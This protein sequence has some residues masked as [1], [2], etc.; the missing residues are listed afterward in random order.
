[1]RATLF[2]LEPTSIAEQ[3]QTGRWWRR[4]AVGVHLVASRADP[5]VFDRWLN[6]PEFFHWDDVIWR[7]RVGWLRRFETEARDEVQLAPIEAAIAREL[8]IAPRPSHVSG[9]S[10]IPASADSRR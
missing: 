9:T 6:G 4:H 3:R 1:M 2:A 10:F 7:R 8:N 5:S